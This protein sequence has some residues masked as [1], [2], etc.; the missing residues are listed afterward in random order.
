MQEKNKIYNIQGKSTNSPWN[1]AKW[2]TNTTFQ[3]QEGSNE[4]MRFLNAKD[5]TAPEA[6]ANHKL[7][8]NPWQI[9]SSAKLDKK[10]PTPFEVE[11]LRFYQM[12]LDKPQDKHRPLK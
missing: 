12:S 6:K 2:M 10:A 3:T 1:Q 5:H 8:L 9:K 4:N 11:N 7:P